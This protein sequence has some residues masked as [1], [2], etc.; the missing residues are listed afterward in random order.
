MNGKAPVLSV[1]MCTAVLILATGVPL[2]ADTLQ[3]KSGQKV[4]G[5]VIAFD[6]KNLKIRS[7][8]GAGSAEVPYPMALVEKVTLTVPPTLGA[9]LAEPVASAVPVLEEYW[10]RW[11]PFLAVP[12]TDSGRVALALAKAHLASGKKK[13]AQTALGLT[14]AVRS[15]DWNSGRK[16]EATRL[17]LTALAASGK[18]EQAMEEASQLENLGGGDESG[19]A[20]ARVR[21]L[22]LKADLAWKKLLKLEESWPKWEE[23]PEQRAEHSKLRQEALDGFVFGA[24]FHPELADL[25]SEGLWKAVEAHQHLQQKDQAIILAR[26]ITGYFP[27]PEFKPRAEQFLKQN[28]TPNK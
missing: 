16:E 9:A 21:S 13:D 18:I 25:A 17:R 22:L 15:Q 2:S 14:E 3:L 7:Q 10:K 26:E 12:E 20:Q 27:S 24:T 19:L 11:E 23:M 1:V 8:F 28:P 4:E 5:E 6:G